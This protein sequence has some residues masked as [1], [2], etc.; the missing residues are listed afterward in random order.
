[1]TWVARLKRVFAIEIGSCRRC[2]GQLRVIASIEEPGVVERILNGRA[3]SASGPRRGGPADGRVCRHG[4]RRHRAA[5]ISGG[6]GEIRES[7]PGQPGAGIGACGGRSG[8]RSL[9]RPLSAER[10]RVLKR[11]IRPTASQPTFGPVPITRT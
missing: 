6:E 7:G 10:G 2:G 9:S 5:G 1:M 4:T 8:I 11:T 3:F